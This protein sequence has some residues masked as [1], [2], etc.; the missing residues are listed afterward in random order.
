MAFKEVLSKGE[1]VF[2]G[3]QLPTELKQILI[4]EIQSKIKQKESKIRASF[5]LKT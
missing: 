3:L 4:K 1:A 5:S 2:E